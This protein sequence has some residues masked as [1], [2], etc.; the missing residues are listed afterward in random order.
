[1]LSSKAAA[2]EEG[3]VRLYVEPMS[4]VRTQLVAC[5]NV[6]LAGECSQ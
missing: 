6:L 5:V 2:S 4:E 3:I 1:M